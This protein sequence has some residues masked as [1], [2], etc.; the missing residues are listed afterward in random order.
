MK[1]P[2]RIHEELLNWARYCWLGEFPH[3]LPPTHCGSLESQYRAPPDWNPDDAPQASYIKPN[4][5]NAIKVQE[6]YDSLWEPEK[7]VLKAEYPDKRKYMSRQHAAGLLGMS[8]YGYETLL[9]IAVSKVEVAFEVC[10]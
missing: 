6:V 4:E 3:P 10:A 8:M 5:R 1:I 2:D 7:I 9:R